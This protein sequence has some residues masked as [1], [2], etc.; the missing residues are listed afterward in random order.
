[1]IQRYHLKNAGDYDLSKSVKIGEGRDQL[2]RDAFFPTDFGVKKTRK[3][4]E[5]TIKHKKIQ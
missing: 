4:Q 2:F 3:I 5:N 1:M